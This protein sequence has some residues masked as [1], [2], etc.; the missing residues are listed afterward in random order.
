M[1]IGD[2]AHNQVPF[3]GQGLNTGFEDLTILFNLFPKE[4][5]STIP[6]GDIFSRYTELRTPDVHTVCELALHNYREMA[7]GVVSVGYKMRKTVED[8]MYR[9]IPWTGVIP[10]YTMVSFRSMRY[11]E[12][13]KKWRAQGRTLCISGIVTILS[14]LG[15]CGY[16]V[17]KLLK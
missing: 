17:K 13:D 11:S 9:Y 10:L 7:S 5:H 1:I 14:M 4:S 3:Y 8:M 16:T 12:V 2:A 6:L 15:I